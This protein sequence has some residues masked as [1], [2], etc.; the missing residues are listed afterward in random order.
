MNFSVTVALLLLSTTDAR[1]RPPVVTVR[2]AEP[3]KLIAGECVEARVAVAVAEGYHL[4]ANPASEDY[5]VATRLELK[6][7]ENISIGQINY[8]KGKPYRLNG[9]DKEIQTYDGSFE[10]GVPLKAARLARPGERTLQGRL[11][12]QACDSKTCLFPTSVPVTLILKI[13]TSSP[14]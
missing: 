7:D 11:H 4:Q 9:A 12:Y 1:A 8:P 3:V 5:L 2:A 6:A 14:R 10:I 13:V